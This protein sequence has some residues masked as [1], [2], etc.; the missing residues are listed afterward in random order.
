GWLFFVR[1]GVVPPCGGPPPARGPQHTPPLRSNAA[2]TVRIMGTRDGWRG[3]IT[4][5]HHKQLIEVVNHG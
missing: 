1:G 4:A 5:A 3:V 2:P